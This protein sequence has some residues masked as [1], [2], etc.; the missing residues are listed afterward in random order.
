VTARRLRGTWESDR[1]P[2]RTL[3]LAADGTYARRF[4]GKTLA[5]LSDVAGPER[6]AWQV[7]G[8]ELVLVE[9]GGQNTRSQRLAIHNIS[10]QS[11]TL[12][13]ERWRRLVDTPVAHR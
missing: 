12:A 9:N 7:E 1:L 3:V 11:V 6:G 5:V 13:G 4:S 2:K 10:P 8:G